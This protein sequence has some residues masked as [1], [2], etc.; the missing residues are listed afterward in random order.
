MQT[1]IL[2]W[3]IRASGVCSDCKRAEDSE[4]CVWWHNVRGGGGGGFRGKTEKV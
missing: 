1:V 2:N 3:E 4:R